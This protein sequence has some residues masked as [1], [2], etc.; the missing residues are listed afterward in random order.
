MCSHTR[1]RV[2]KSVLLLTTFRKRGKLWTG[3]NPGL[4]FSLFNFYNCRRT[5]GTAALCEIRQ[6]IV[7][8]ETQVQLSSVYQ[9]LK[10]FYSLITE[11]KHNFVH[12]TVNFRLEHNTIHLKHINYYCWQDII[13]YVAP[14]KKK[15]LRSI[16]QN[17]FG[18]N[19]NDDLENITQW[20]N[21]IKKSSFRCVN[22]WV[23]YH[24]RGF[25]HFVHNQ[26]TVILI[27]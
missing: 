27:V 11:T 25:Y 16:R 1:T 2:G 12:F 8:A 19:N 14:R 17:L 20:V 22:T 15:Q 7:P 4:P 18:T 9:Q 23:D 13:S 3:A 21:I 24:Q 10:S 6:E 26:E 5:H